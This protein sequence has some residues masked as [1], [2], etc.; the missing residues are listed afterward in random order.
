MSDTES[1]ENVVDFPAAQEPPPLLIGPFQYHA[2]VVDGRQVP[3]LT[4]RPDGDG[5]ALVVDHRFTATFPPELARQ[6]AWLIAEATAVAQ[7][8]PHFG[9]ASKDRPFAPRMAEL[10]KPDQ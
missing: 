5:I 10:G 1:G 9:A 6:A 2:V 3:G 8:Y 7:G 4:G